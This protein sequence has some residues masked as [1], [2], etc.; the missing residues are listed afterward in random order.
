MSDNIL[1]LHAVPSDPDPLRVKTLVLES[2]PP[3][4]AG[5]SGPT[6]TCAVTEN[7]RGL[8]GRPSA[9][10]MTESSPVQSE[11]ITETVNA[12]T[13]ISTLSLPSLNSSH[14]GLYYCQGSLQIQAMEDGSITVNSSSI[15]I[16]VRCESLIITADQLH[17]MP[18]VPTPVVSVSIPTGPLYE[19]TSQTL[20]CTATLAASVDT[21]ITVSV[22][23]TG[24]DFSSSSDRIT[25]SH[26]ST[27]RS[28]FIS[29][30]TLSPLT[31]ADAGQYRCQVT[32]TSSSPYITDSTPG[33][34]IP[35]SLTVTGISTFLFACFMSWS[36]SALPA[37]DISFTFSGV[38]IVG[39]TYSLQCSATLAAVL[40][41]QPDMK[42]AFPNS[43]EI[44]QAINS[45]IEYRFNSLRI[46]DG[47][48]YTC[49][50]T[51]NIPQAGIADLHTSVTK[52]LT[53][54]CKSTGA[55]TL[56]MIMCCY[57]RCLCSRG[58]Q[59]HSSV[60]ELSLILLESAQHCREPHHWL[61]P[62]L[63]SSPDW[64]PSPPVS[65]AGPNCHLSH[66][67]W[68]QIWSLLQLLNLHHH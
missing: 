48:Q 41:V 28:P 40:V 32:A 58:L 20:N 8:T 55:H 47:G 56:A 17:S 16:T 7:I 9:V 3:L 2:G 12:T 35:Q 62:D 60:R 22:Q 53:V 37:P 29:T 30:L 59:E 27:T 46:S 61:Q 45:S 66:C 54:V 21:N 15:N 18:A 14:A 39:Q 52:T 43:T 24:P 68:T 11:Y 42:I 57:F 63:C 38:S 1:S 25:I 6:L 31:R 26:P 34:S 51:I 5:S 36:S 67:G 23:W 64:Y 44:S 10:W 13:A 4:V 33:E 50:S 19:G 65:P 49:T